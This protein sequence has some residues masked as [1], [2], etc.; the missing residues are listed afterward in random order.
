MA[1]NFSGGMFDRPGLYD[2]TGLLSER[3][4]QE[5]STI[6]N[7]RGSTASGHTLHT[8]TAGKVAFLKEI[9]FMLND[10]GGGGAS[11]GVY[12]R[13][14]G[15]GGSIEVQIGFPAW[16]VNKDN[17]YINLN[18]PIKFTT[19]IYFHPFNSISHMVTITGWEEK[20]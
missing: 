4:N 5:G 20:A 16:M 7:S 2:E 1:L 6:I 18:V 11:E 17:I 9:V 19:D 8:V 12:I 15:S 13:D 3:W 10:A 14:G